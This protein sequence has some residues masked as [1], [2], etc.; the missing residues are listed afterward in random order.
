MNLHNQELP[1]EVVKVI[2]E[3]SKAY[4]DYFDQSWFTMF[5]DDCPITNG[6]FHD[7]RS[8][9][10]I[11]APSRADI[12][13]LQQ[14]IAALEQFILFT[15]EIIIPRVTEYAGNRNG[16][17][18]SKSLSREMSIQRK[19]IS[20]SLPTNIKSLEELVMRLKSLL[21]TSSGRFSPGYTRKMPGM[22]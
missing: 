20:Y 3:I 7:I 14:C 6:Q 12:P 9:L 1:D 8:A 13:I 4:F 22:Y 10:T 5:L 19:I 21:P 15:K 2:K 11:I 17:N 18:M 16:K